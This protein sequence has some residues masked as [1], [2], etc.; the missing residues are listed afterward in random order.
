[1]TTDLSMMFGISSFQFNDTMHWFD[2][3]A[4]YALFKRLQ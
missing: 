1:V 4:Y 2:Q 3:R